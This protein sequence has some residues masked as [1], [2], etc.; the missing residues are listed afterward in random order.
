[1]SMR[2]AAPETPAGRALN[3]Y[4][5]L[6]KLGAGGMGQIW[7][8]HDLRLGRKVALKLLPPEVVADSTRRKRFERESRA[9]AALNHPNIVIIHS[10]EEADG[11]P[12][13]VMEHI[14]GRSL[15]ELIPAGGLPFER[16]LELA[17]PMVEAI[18]QAHGSGIVHRDLKPANVMVRD[19]GVVKVVDFGISKMEEQTVAE[20]FPAVTELRTA[21]GIAIGTIPYMSPEQLEGAS[22]D[23]RSDLF[24]LGV[25]LYEMATGRRPFAEGSSASM[26]SSILRDPP[27]PLTTRDKAVPARFEQIVLRCLA[28]DPARRFLSAADLGRALADLRTDLVLDIAARSDL[29]LPT[30]PAAT[31]GLEAG[32]AV[33][34][35]SPGPAARPVWRRWPVLLPVTAGL[36]A[37]L[38]VAGMRWHPRPETA[39]APAVERSFTMPVTGRPVA[40]AIAVLPLENL[41]GDPGQEYFSDGTTEAVI[42]SLAKIGGLRVTSRTSVMRFKASRTSLPQ[43]ARDLGVSYVLEGSLSKAAD[44]V[45]ITTRL[46]DAASDTVLWGDR[47]QGKLENIFAF[48]E[49]VAEEVARATRVEVT[50]DDRS[51]LAQVQPV[52]PEVYEQ[53]L[54]ARFL[55]NQRTPP[56]LLKALEQLDG[57]LRQEPGYALAWA[58]R[59]E[60]Y[61]HLVSPGLAVIPAR[62]GVAKAR[63]AARKAIELDGTL[64]EA[65]VVLGFALME[66]WSWRE[67][68][69][70][71]VR[72]IKI[73]PSNADAYAKY[74][75][76]LTAIGR[77]QEAIEAIEKARKLDPLSPAIS[78]AAAS[79]YRLA[80]DVDQ[81]IAASKATLDLEP[82]F[83]LGYYQLGLSYSNVGR[84]AEADAEL[85]KALASGPKPV[86]LAALGRNA[87]RCG[88]LEETR[89]ILGQLQR[90][91]EKGAYLPPS[92]LAKLHFLL[93]ENEQGFVWLQKAL[94]ERD[95]TLLLIQIDPDYAAVREDP[96]F[97]RVLDRVGVRHD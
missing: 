12:F 43:I 87:A 55:M 46:V 60:C 14:E 6:R 82:D 51:R 68:G 30:L 29:T 8:A 63:E 38:G 83:W 95:Q 54:K 64:S 20:G 40:V 86:V 16:C 58:A 37:I 79:T 21:E 24:S 93:G 77:H 25:L 39:V 28:K 45:V 11:Q 62:D 90:M 23:A 35:P 78:Q 75:F 73:N 53:Y 57:V 42:A 44:Q 84:C 17:I 27:Q 71:L 96:R 97:L 80:G 34:A 85:Q 3:H 48:Q 5:L 50:G 69:Q 31:R 91:M 89:R 33:G 41:S 13:L 76:Y 4:Q 15:E 61:S 66:S 32:S 22:V 65:H 26:I 47:F 88:R 49:K 36:V 52:R 18:A 72:A 81:A 1:M 74:T 59:S 94:D 7:L 67:A 19:D 10:I 56:A 70:E 9:L 2:S 92:L